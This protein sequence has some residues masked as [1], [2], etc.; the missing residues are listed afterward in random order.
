MIGSVGS[1]TGRDVRTHEHDRDS[2]HRQGERND[3]AGDVDGNVLQRQDAA[4][5][6]VSSRRCRAS[7][8]FAD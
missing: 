1:A 7:A 3:D 4:R 6:S 2:G 5:E 8:F